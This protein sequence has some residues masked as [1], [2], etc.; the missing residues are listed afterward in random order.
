MKLGNNRK[1]H[2]IG[3]CGVGMSGVAKL[4]K[5]QGWQVTGSDEGFYPPVSDYLKKYDIPYFSCYASSN[6]PKDVDLIV[7]GKHAKLVPE[8]NEEVKTAFE[9]G[10][11]VK[12]YPEILNQLTSNTENIVI[13]GSFGKSTC[14]SLVAWTL[15]QAGKDPS[16]FIGGFPLNLTD[17]AHL[18]S[19]NIFVLEGDEYPSANWDSTSK[20]LYYN[21]HSVLLISAEHDHFN[22]FQTLDS[23]LEPY[24]KLVKQLPQAGVLVACLDGENVEEVLKRSEATIGGRVVTTYALRQRPNVDW[25]AEN[26][27][28]GEKTTFNLMH[29]GTKVADITTLLVGEHNIQNL[30]GV[31]A[32][33]LT[34]NICSVD[35]LVNSFKEFRGVKRRLELK[36]VNTSIPV[37]EDF[38]SSR[39]KAIAGL[40][41]IRKQFPDRRLIVIFEPHTFSFR[42]RNALSW[43]DDL[44]SPADLVFIYKPPT[45]GAETHDQLSQLEIVE[46]VRKSGKEVYSINSKEH[47]LELLI[48]ILQ[49]KRDVLLM[50]TSGDLG[51][52]IEAVTAYI[53]THLALS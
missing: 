48:P 4:L 28:L 37:Y 8:E 24:I 16:Y 34:L 25:W 11:P 3:I 29:K 30:V 6:I 42:N 44:F 51:G 43:Y 9:L 47:L 15:I 22:V 14:A 13:A 38:G 39:A 33:L 20:F 45:H 40:M 53:N 1:A 17:H 35:G 26:I 31:A 32:L 18:G 7:I 10:V 12:S 36:T 23:Y 46:A 41:A 50:I 19:G 52:S 21:P 5:E 2:F 49:P 27:R